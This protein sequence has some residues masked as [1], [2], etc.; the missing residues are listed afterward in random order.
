MGGFVKDNYEFKSAVHIGNTYGTSIGDIKLVGDFDLYIELKFLKR[1]TG[2][3]ANI[4]QDALTAND[5]FSHD[6]FSWSQFREQNKFSEHVFGLLKNY[7]SNEI[8]ILQLPL[9]SANLQKLG[10]LVRDKS[11]FDVKAQSIKG[12]I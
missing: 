11:K 7:E 8:D 12:A 1:G 4:S 2:T 5:I 3:R 9:T 10:R 6:T